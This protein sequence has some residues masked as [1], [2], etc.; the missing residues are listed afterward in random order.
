MKKSYLAAALALVIVLPA[1][2][3]DSVTLKETHRVPANTN[4]HFDV[5]IGE[6]ELETY[7]GDEVKLSVTV[8]IKDDNW[9]SDDDLS[10]A[11]MQIEVDGDDVYFAVNKKEN[12]QDWKILLPETAN[13]DLDVG[14]GSVSIEGVERTLKVDLGVGEITAE[15][16]SNDYRRIDLDSG[17]GEV[18]VSGLANADVETSIVS[19]SLDWRGGGEYKLDID[20]GVGGIDVTF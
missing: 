20:V 9:F 6:I 4:L 15:M 16:A 18:Q 8:S 7:S 12:Q 14:V 11:E 10:D 3:D 13:I 1:C 2:A 5:P 19:E 17:V